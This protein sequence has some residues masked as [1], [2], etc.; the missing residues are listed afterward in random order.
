[1]VSSM[2]CNECGGV[3]FRFTEDHD[4]KELN[5]DQLSFFIPVVCSH[6]GKRASRE[7]SIHIR[8]LQKFLESGE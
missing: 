4:G 8:R 7:T 3:N 2:E 1:M 5:D 6:C